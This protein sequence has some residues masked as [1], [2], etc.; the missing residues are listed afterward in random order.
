M[1][2][3]IPPMKIVVSIDHAPPPRAWPHPL[4]SLEL[5]HTHL[6]HPPPCAD[7]LQVEDDSGYI[8]GGQRPNT[9]PMW[10]W[11][12]PSP[13][14]TPLDGRTEMVPGRMSVTVLNNSQLVTQPSTP[15]KFNNATL[16]SQSPKPRRQLF[17]CRQ[18]SAPAQ[19]VN[20]NGMM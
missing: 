4:P 2:R 3:N 10:R 12:L 15:T 9:L 13:E 14:T 18:R 11:M 7:D 8:S 5:G 1:L 20:N 17:V 19:L 6:Y 16:V